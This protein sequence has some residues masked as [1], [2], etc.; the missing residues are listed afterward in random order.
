[1][2]DNLVFDIETTSLKPWKGRIICI[3]MKDVKHDKTYVYQ[4]ENEQELVR[5]FVSYCNRRNFD[6]VI[7][8]NVTFDMRYVFGKAAK[9]RIK[10]PDFFN[11]HYHDLMQV[12]KSVR[13]MYSTNQPGT[14]DDWAKYLL[15]DE[16]LL[17]TENVPELYKQGEVEKIN[18]YCRKD[19]ELTYRLWKRTQQVLK[20][21]QGNT[22]TLQKSLKVEG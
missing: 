10:A 8:Y 1:M 6:Q 20:K 18:K 16:K 17:Q 14:L 11:T 19:V 15:D 22:P 13:P 2:K 12:M 4:S 3:A 21:Q 7:G 9:Y 5:K